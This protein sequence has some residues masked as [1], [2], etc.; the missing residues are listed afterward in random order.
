MHSTSYEVLTISLAVAGKIP[1]QRPGAAVTSVT[2]LSAPVGTT[3]GLN[4][5]E[6][7]QSVPLQTALRWKPDDPCAAELTGA[8]VTVPSPPPGGQAV[9]VVVSGG[10]SSFAVGG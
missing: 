10:D 1:L 5:G 8:Y 9:I 4:I 7:G 2:V 3:A 6:L